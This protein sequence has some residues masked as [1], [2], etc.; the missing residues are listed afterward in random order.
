[1]PPELVNSSLKNKLLQRSRA[2][3]QVR[4][5]L[6]NNGYIEADPS[7]LRSS[8]CVDPFIQIF[9]TSEDDTTPNAKAYFLQSSPEI[10][11]K[12]LL[13]ENPGPIYYLGPAWRQ[14]EEGKQHRKEFTMLEWYRADSDQRP[15]CSLPHLV[16][17]L[18]DDWSDRPLAELAVE[19]LTICHK[20]IGQPSLDIAQ[21]PAYS[22][23]KLLYHL[24]SIDIYTWAQEQIYQQIKAVL[25]MSAHDS[26]A[27]HLSSDPLQKAEQMSCALSLYIDSVIEPWLSLKHPNSFALLC[28]FIGFYPRRADCALAQNDQL[29]NGVSIVKRFELYHGNIELANGYRELSCGIE[30][31]H[32]QQ[33]AYQIKGINSQKGDAMIDWQLIK[34]F[35]NESFPAS[36]G[37]A[38]GFDRLLM[39]QLK[40][41]KNGPVEINEVRVDY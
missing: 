26:L 2:K 41:Y 39:Q 40:Q 18:N 30:M 10:A 1:M 35:K 27:N 11:L 28:D 24:S 38:V 17:A 29:T 34:K 37:V 32:R 15:F 23:P 5:L 33:E 19:T 4:D 36:C 12:H 13:C 9:S 3:Q 16:Q 14:G 31:Q 7:A 8:C 6:H 25:G 21:T 20:I 22:L